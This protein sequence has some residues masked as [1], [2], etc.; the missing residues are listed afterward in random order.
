MFN[1]GETRSP[2]NS[3]AS[4]PNPHYLPTPPPSKADED[5]PP[6]SAGASFS[7]TVSPIHT[8]P[9]RASLHSPTHFK[10]LINFTE[11]LTK[12]SDSLRLIPG[13]GRNA[14]LKEGLTD[15]ASDF[16]PS[17]YLYLPL[18]VTFRGSGDA[19]DADS[20]TKN[21]WNIVGLH[22]QESMVFSTKERCPYLCTLEIVDASHGEDDA[23][24][25]HVGN[26]KVSSSSRKERETETDTMQRIS[27]WWDNR[28]RDFEEVRRYR[29]RA[30]RRAERAG[31]MSLLLTISS[32]LHRSSQK[33]LTSRSQRAVGA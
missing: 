19:D 5:S 10:E 13:Y 28:K 9:R 23:D 11:G 12:L 20:G 15:L 18:Q 16:L 25:E 7:D 22:G 21:F 6:P 4:S 30:Q 1:S 3:D 2:S 29:R 33:N 17:N 8:M 14:Q 32:L 27:D 31:F 24:A 26:E